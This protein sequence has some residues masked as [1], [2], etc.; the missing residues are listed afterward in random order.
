M[1][2]LIV[3]DQVV[4]GVSDFL[5]AAFP[6]STQGFDQLIETFLETPDTL[7]HGPYLTIP[8]PFRSSPRAGTRV[9]PW[10]SASFVPHAHQAKAFAQLSGECA[11]SVVVATGTG[12]GKTECFLYPI[13]EHCRV[14]HANGERGIKAIILYPMNALATDQ[15]SRVAK[16]ILNHPALNQLRAGL[17]VGEKPDQTYKTVTQT[18]DQQYSL[19]SDRAELRNNPPDI[20][21]TNY[22]ML[23]FLL[24]R[25]DDA[26]LWQHQEPHTLR[27]LVVDELHT[28]DGAQGTDLACL[29]RRLK[30]R[31]E[32]PSQHLLCVGTSATL[33]DDQDAIDS[34]TH[35]ASDIF[36]EP[37]GQDQIIRE[38]RVSVGEYLEESVV[39]YILQPQAPDEATLDPAQYKSIDDYLA[40]QY[41]IWFGKPVQPMHIS[42]YQWRCELG[43]SLKGHFAFQNLL[44]DLDRLGGRSVPVQELV[45]LLTR[46]ISKRD[47]A[48]FAKLWLSS[49]LSL[50]AHARKD[51]HQDF[52][53]QVKVEIWLR[54]LRRMVAK[55]DPMPT[56]QHFDSL[57]SNDRQAVYLPIVYCRD[58]HATGWGAMQTKTGGNQLVSDLQSFYT[59]FFAEDPSTRFLFPQQDQQQNKVF[60]PKN[61]CLRCA[62]LNQ[63]VQSVCDHCGHDQLMPIVV[64]ESLKEGTRHGATLT[65]SSRDCPYCQSPNAIS[66]LGSQ[67][68]SLASVMIGQIYSSR[69][70]QDRKLIA[71][72]DSVQDAAHRAGFFA[73]RTWKL[74]LRPALAQVIA[75]AQDRGEALTLAELPEAFAQ[76]WQDRLGIDHYIANFLP[77]QLSWLRDIETLHAT[78]HLPSDSTVPKKFNDILP[79][80]IQSEFGQ[81]AHIGRTLIATGTVEVV[82][83]AALLLRASEWLRPRLAENIGLLKALSVQDCK[84]FLQALIK[85]MQRIGAWWH[86]GLKRYAAHGCNPYLYKRSPTEYK[87][88]TAARSPRFLSVCDFK[89]CVSVE[90][91]QSQ[92]FKKLLFDAWPWLHEWALLSPVQIRSIYDWGLGALQQTG[93][94]QS[95]VSDP[96]IGQP[97]EVWGLSAD[98]F[99]VQ[100]QS[101]N[102]DHPYYFFRHLYLTAAIQ[103]VVAHEHTGLLPRETRERVEHS[104]K[105]NGNQAGKINLLSATPTLEMG[106]DIGDLSAT[107]MCSVPPK[108]A[109]YLQR[110]G[111]AGRSTGNALL[112]TVALSR[113]HD[114]YF[115][116]EPREMLTGS[117]RAPGVYLNASAVLERQLTAFT[118]DCWVSEHGQAGSQIPQDIRHVLSAVR[119]AAHLKFPF[120][121]LQY[122]EQHRGRLLDRFISLFSHHGES[123]LDP[124]THTWL[125][126]FINGSSNEAG[127][128]AWKII[129][130]LNAMVKDIDEFKR[131][132]EKIDRQRKKIEE[133]AVLGDT[134]QQDL[135]NLQQEKMALSRLIASIEG[136]PT[137]QVLTDEGLLPN[138]AFP[139]QG[140]LLRSIILREQNTTGSAKNLEPLTFEYERPSSTAITELAPNNT[141][142]AE[143]RRVEINQVDVSKVKP[144]PWRFCRQCSY[145][146]PIML[147][148]HDE[149]CP[150][151]KDTFWRDSGR[152]RD[153]LKLT[154]VFARTVDRE[155]RISDDSD[156]RKRGFY[157]REALV[158]S[159]PVD[160]TEGYVVD[161]PEFPFGFEFLSRVSF[162]EINFGERELHASP[163]V[164]AGKD[165]PRA[166][167]AICPEC[168]TLQRK[169]TAEEQYRNHA[170][171][172]S[173]RKA[174]S[175]PTQQCVFLYREFESEGVR[176]YLADANDDASVLSF[177]AG[178]Q[179]GLNRH[180][181]G[182][183][184]HLRI[185]LDM[186]MSVGQQDPQYYLVI[187]DSVPGGTGYLKGLMRDE[188]PLF[189]VFEAGLTALNTCACNQDEHKDGCYHCVF[190]YQNSVD[191]QH[192]SRRLAQRILTNIVAE[193]ANLKVVA[194][195][196]A[197]QPSN[198]LFDSELE[199]RF[200]EVL[201]REHNGIKFDITEVL[202]KG[203]PCY[204]VQAGQR[205]WRLEPQVYLSEQQGVMIA[206]K[207]DFV[208]WPDDQTLDLPIALFLDGWKYHQHSI[209]DDLAKRMAIAKS[210]QFSVWTLTWH[211]LEQLNNPTK[212]VKPPIWSSLIL[213]DAVQGHVVTK[214]TGALGVAS[215]SSWHELPSFLQLHS[216]LAQA[217]HQQ[218]QR[219]ASALAIS[220]SKPK[221]PHHT[222]TLSADINQHAFWQQ[223]QHSD[224]L[225][226]GV[227]QIQSDRI[228]SALLWWRMQINN[229][230]LRELL[231]GTW[232]PSNAP[233][234]IGF[235]ND[236]AHIPEQERQSSWQTLWQIINVMLP[237]PHCWAGTADMPALDHL[238]NAGIFHAA[239]GMHP[240]W[241]GV[242][243]VAASE[244]QEL[245]M[246]LATLGAP[247]PLVG[248]EL[249]DHN[250]LVIAEAELAWPDQRVVLLLDGMSEREAVWVK[251]GWSCLSTAP[252]I[253]EHVM[254]MITAGNL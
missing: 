238:K 129:N 60:T 107:L 20:L 190:V 12:S 140:V 231:T 163:M 36:A 171:Y 141:F 144:E 186:R 101:E 223:L 48:R 115:W 192:V 187:Y 177:V 180:F 85:Q 250:Q 237:L 67:A 100:I 136:K 25:A 161:R 79:W 245:L 51:A 159:S 213:S 209:A 13:L 121:W 27:Y 203:K 146:M 45:K 10:L 244:V 124:T 147:G 35:F 30:G 178:L 39:E 23:D 104:F 236:L 243:E 205:R 249:L 72:S 83:D 96:S 133:K 14:A 7:F 16:D 114:L 195:L 143:G 105:S 152:V 37:I 21:L 240:E 230:Q 41:L 110:A 169:R 219:L 207:P 235:W 78:G 193:K 43:E 226:S 71:F 153:M 227:S 63:T 52:F 91:D 113:P 61:I 181:R 234:L 212:D 126:T 117:V 157:L 69:F 40:A 53:L 68:A 221:V 222:V 17:Y 54:E 164:I 89:K 122:V 220:L 198:K 184:D 172:C 5:R 218:L 188:K 150:R 215:L 31:L 134:D 112:A 109:N 128:L 73:A 232:S 214:M 211:D 151:C 11:R 175:S 76:Y 29:I 59:A 28:F 162:R 70:N 88:L 9:Y 8:L 167:F 33:G 137:L 183:V 239:S 233:Q 138:Y 217:T 95:E 15:A 92:V 176:I 224:V 200:V 34:L 19:I 80:L 194:G 86:D 106:I 182:A 65:K 74:N 127:S 246:E 158:D 98:A 210:G 32:T 111:R 253:L 90:K 139:E 99:T 166:G 26:G 103:R 118:L 130:H 116:E 228:S 102:P 18:G 201:R 242:F 82:A 93:L 62:A 1:Q 49:L 97:T 55:L 241:L 3:A 47:D 142:Y 123:K 44:R 173:M 135:S 108:Q 191:R 170:P 4:Q 149:S 168:G 251:H 206:S 202:I 252:F 132:R 148:D 185:A 119:T 131:Q 56:L 81:E 125:Q 229:D 160:V 58:C 155:S 120:P 145:A 24:M 204:M 87:L 189:E 84:Q 254:S 42:Q 197:I 22:K 179:L 64:A 6:S 248:F 77:P 247:I 199:K 50:V 216:R 94:A 208:F 156:E 2:P 38:D 225:A 57:G 154:T 66:I 46:R 165:Q 174:D 196:G 75:A